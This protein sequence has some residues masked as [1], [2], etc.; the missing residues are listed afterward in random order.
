MQQTRR[1][2]QT[3]QTGH[4]SYLTFAW[5]P[6]PFLPPLAFYSSFLP[7]IPTCLF[8]STLPSA[9]LDTPGVLRYSAARLPL[10]PASPLA[11]PEASRGSP[12][13]TAPSAASCTSLPSISPRIPTF[14]VRLTEGE[15]RRLQQVR[16]QISVGV[17]G[18]LREDLGVLGDGGVHPVVASVVGPVLRVRGWESRRG[19]RGRFGRDHAST[20]SWASRRRRGCGS[21]SCT[22]PFAEEGPRRAIG[23]SSKREGNEEEPL[24]SS[25]P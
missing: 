20:G 11:S 4:K 5:K 8:R 14:L 9:P 19:W 23:R 15:R 10:P 24:R 22:P 21:S 18:V 25:I 6:F 17:A 2:Q 13:A 7:S 3:I 1:H 12:P 16:A